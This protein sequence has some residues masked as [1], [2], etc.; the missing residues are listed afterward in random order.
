MDLD[1]LAELDLEEASSE[2]ALPPPQSPFY[3]MKKG[4]GVLKRAYSE[5][6]LKKSAPNVLRSMAPGKAFAAILGFL[7]GPSGEHQ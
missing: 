7:R 4:S 1:F 6:A 2:L 5:K 3:P